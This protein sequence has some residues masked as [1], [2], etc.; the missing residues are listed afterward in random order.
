MIIFIIYEAENRQLLATGI[1]GSGFA[2]KVQQH[3]RQKHFIRRR[4]PAAR[5]IQCLW[6]HYA[7]IP[8]SRSIATWKVHLAV[9][10]PSDL[11]SVSDYGE[12]ESLGTVGFSIGKWKSKTKGGGNG[13]KRRSHN[14]SLIHQQSAPLVASAGAATSTVNTGS[15]L[16]AQDAQ[17][18]VSRF[19]FHGRIETHKILYKI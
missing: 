16:L 19:L 8:E 14:D 12:I 17:D 11:G 13:G 1:L 15:W 2:L 7:A 10:P 18:P 3:Q 5:L 9:Q 4:V 6:R